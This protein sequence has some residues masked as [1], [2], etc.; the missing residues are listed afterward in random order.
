MPAAWVVCSDGKLRELRWTRCSMVGRGR[1][2]ISLTTDGSAAQPAAITTRAMSSDGR[3]QRRKRRNAIE[4]GASKANEPASLTICAT[5]VKASLRLNAMACSAW[6][7]NPGANP[8]TAIPTSA[9]TTASPKKMPRTRI[10]KA[11]SAA[12]LVMVVVPE[13]RRG[14]DLQSAGDDVESARNLAGDL[15]VQR[16]VHRRRRVHRQ[17]RHL[18]HPEAPEAAVQSDGG[19]DRGANQPPH[20]E[21]L[22]QQNV[23]RP[24]VRRSTRNLQIE[25]AAEDRG[26]DDRQVNQLQL[27]PSFVVFDL[28]GEDRPLFECQG[29]GHGVG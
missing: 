4:S 25:E 3:F 9:V 28:A 10:E 17:A 13:A 21:V 5:E 11:A 8:R 23:E 18:H 7:S 14:D 27:L 19:V 1:A 15:A 22:H 20:R 26:V 16:H 6:T 2:T 24:V 29:G 12:R